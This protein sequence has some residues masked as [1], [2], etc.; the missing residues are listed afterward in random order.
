MTGEDSHCIGGEFKSPFPLLATGLV[1]QTHSKR[2]SN[3]QR[4][5]RGGYSNPDIHKD[6]QERVIRETLTQIGETDTPKETLKQ[7]E[8]NIM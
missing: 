6:I 8:R 3:K 7:T 2:H 4:V 1:R 5:T